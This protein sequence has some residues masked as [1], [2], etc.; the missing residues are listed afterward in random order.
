MRS[1]KKLHWTTILDAFEH[2]TNLYKF[3]TFYQTFL[4]I[5]DILHLHWFYQQFIWTIFKK[6]LL[7]IT[8]EVLLQWYGNP[9]CKPIDIEETSIAVSKALAVVRSTVSNK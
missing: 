6:D 1:I 3:D 8:R 4:S 9:W 5:I 7:L 2:V